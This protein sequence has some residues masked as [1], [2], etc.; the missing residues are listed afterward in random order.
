MRLVFSAAWDQMNVLG[1][2]KT[3][4]TLHWLQSSGQLAPSLTG[5]ST[6]GGEASTVELALMV[7]AQVKQLQSKIELASPPLP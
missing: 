6:S 5:H 4:P 3:F 1:L 2:Y 7:G